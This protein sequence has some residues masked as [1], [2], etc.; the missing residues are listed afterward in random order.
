MTK[1]YLYNSF[2]QTAIGQA[3][4]AYIDW[5][6]GLAVLLMIEAHTIDA[7]T[8]LADKSLPAYG[9]GTVLGGFAAPL[10][11][12]LAGLGV[13]MSMARTYARTG[14]RDAALQ[15]AIA[16]GLEIFLLA[17]VFRL[18]ALIVSPGGHPIALFRVD[19]LNVMGPAMVATALLWTLSDRAA[20]RIALF[21]GAALT[22][23]MVTPV[24]R[25]SPL[26]DRLPL[27]FQWYLRPAGEFTT[28]TMLP[29]A[30]FVFAGA[31]VGV[32]LASSSDRRALHLCVGA[33]GMLA[34]A[35]GMY[36]AS[37]PTIYTV[38]T[39]FWTSSPTFFVVRVGILMAALSGLSFVPP[40]KML[41][42][43]ATLGR[44]SLF[45]YWIHVELVYGYASWLWRHRL[46][47]WAWAL[48]YVA[49][50][51]VMYR[52]IGWRDAIVASWRQ[53]R[54]AAASPAGMAS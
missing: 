15:S 36:A 21:A 20:I 48:G 24:V 47:L 16:R 14:D 45:V 1:S 25:A 3:R 28:F 12:W 29:W 32:L 18:Q 33:V 27:W 34:I 39:N 46:P 26:V 50:A 13:A 2:V 4:R 30:G 44:A 22:I 17:F 6:R 31:A 52:A 10:F 7:W 49:F 40:V 23:A 38:P 5:A 51:L 19:V 53:R 37:R 42:P 9:Y 43:L 11:L 8:R 54:V 35:L 41:Q